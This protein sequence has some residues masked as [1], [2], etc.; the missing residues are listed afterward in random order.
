MVRG[1]LRA[2]GE[3]V[4]EDVVTAGIAALA[5]GGAVTLIGALIGDL[6]MRRKK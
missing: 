6:I 4:M 1:Y 3:R 5:L 2:K